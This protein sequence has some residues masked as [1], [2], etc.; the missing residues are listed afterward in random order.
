[1]ELTFLSLVILFL[2]LIP[3]LG[4]GGRWCRKGVARS[5]GLFLFL[6]LVL[7]IGKGRGLHCVSEQFKRNK[8]MGGR[9]KSAIKITIWKD[10]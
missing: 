3:F 10:I 6:V 9:S 5:S 2:I 8:F 1:V 7:G 4:W